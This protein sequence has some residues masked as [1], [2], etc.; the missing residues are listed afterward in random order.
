[1]IERDNDRTIIR[2]GEDRVIIREDNRIII[3][4]DDSG[5]L[6]RNAR[7]VRTDRRPNGNTATTVVRPN[8]T[9]IVTVRD[10]FGNIVSRTRVDPAGRE[11]VLIE[12]HRGPDRRDRYGRGIGPIIELP[13]LVL[14]IPRERYIVEADEAPLPLIEETLIAPPVERVERAYSL[15]EIRRNYRILE[16]VRSIDLNTINFEFGA[17]EIGDDQIDRLETI[18]TAIEDIVKKNP[19]EVFLIEGHTDAVGSDE[20]NLALSDRRAESVAI[21]LTEHFDIPA[22]NLITQG[23]GEEQ[24]KVQTESEERENRRVTLRR[25]TPLLTS[26]AQ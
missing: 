14:D 4:N 25:I 3:Q 26:N 10:E 13:P 7:D 20:D 23:Y 11:I 22:E 21:I 9:R 12:E 2:D 17:W 8:G 15:G 6:S 24:L 5:R 19:E 16:K 18:G 1:M